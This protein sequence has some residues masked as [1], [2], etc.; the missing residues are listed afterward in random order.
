MSPRGALSLAKDLLSAL[1]K[2]KI[3][4]KNRAVRLNLLKVGSPSLQMFWE[5]TLQPMRYV[6]EP[7]AA[8]SAKG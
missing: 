1:A 2:K 5:A 6:R 3:N 8:T 4:Q 7:D